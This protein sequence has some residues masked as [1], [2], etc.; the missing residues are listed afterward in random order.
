MG[1][2]GSGR[3]GGRPT[4]DASLRIELPHLRRTGYFKVG[5]R[6]SGV[7]YLVFGIVILVGIIYSLVKN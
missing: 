3:Y 6:V 7:L 2:W 1:G 4:V 5:H